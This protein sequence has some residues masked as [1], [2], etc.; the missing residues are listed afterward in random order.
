VAVIQEVAAYLIEQREQIGRE[1]INFIVDKNDGDP[2]NSE[3]PEHASNTAFLCERL[4]RAFGSDADEHYTALMEWTYKR[5]E[6][7]YNYGLRLKDALK[8]YSEMR[9]AFIRI[10]NRYCGSRKMTA[11][12]LI[13]VNNQFVS[14]IGS[15]VDSSIRAFIEFTDKSLKE[16][17][18]E[19]S[20]LS[21]PLV[22]VQNGVAILPLIGS[23]DSYRAKHILQHV[24]PRVADLK[25]DYLV[26]DFSGIHMVDTLV[27]D[28]LFK[29]EQVLGLLGVKAVASGIRPEVAQAVVR[30]GIDLTTLKSF[31]T[32]KQALEHINP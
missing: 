16:A 9:E 15:A 3:L 2:N 30:M 22:P 8:Y 17:H 21:A 14:L 13:H 27:V 31:A 20:L 24:V 1:V 18:E 32:V 5:G 12:E 4:G 29:I 26:I 28:Y 23:I 6:F 10:V 7:S 25:V 19:V 11:D